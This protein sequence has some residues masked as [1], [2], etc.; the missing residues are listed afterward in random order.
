MIITE[1]AATASSKSPRSRALSIVSAA[2]ST[3]PLRAYRGEATAPINI[4]NHCPNCEPQFDARFEM[5]F[6]WAAIKRSS[7]RRSLIEFTPFAENWV[8]MSK[9]GEETA[10]S[11]RFIFANVNYSENGAESLTAP[12]SCRSA[13][14]GMF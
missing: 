10:A 13:R 8:N 14:T 11:L 6:D 2:A 12:C 9:A 4:E 5:E 1:A 3:P 7:L